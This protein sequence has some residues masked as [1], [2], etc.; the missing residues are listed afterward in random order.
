MVYVLTAFAISFIV[1]FVIL[2]KE[3][4]LFNKYS[5]LNKDLKDL[6]VVEKEKYD[7][8]GH[9]YISNRGELNKYTGKILVDVIN[10]I[11]NDKVRTKFIYYGYELDLAIFIFNNLLLSEDCSIENKEDLVIDQIEN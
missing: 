7:E 6:V 3:E 9:I 5:N 1:L 4:I 10:H 11:E 8:H 2:L